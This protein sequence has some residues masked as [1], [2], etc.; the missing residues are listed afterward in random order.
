[1]N[2][3]IAGSVVGMVFRWPPFKIIFIQD[4]QNISNFFKWSKCQH[5]ML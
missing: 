4:G 3:T 1:M 2:S 5:A